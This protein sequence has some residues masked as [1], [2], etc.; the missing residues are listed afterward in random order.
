[1]R[2]AASQCLKLRLHLQ[3]FFVCNLKHNL[4]R[5]L[6]LDKNTNKPI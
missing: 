1:M 2:P 6:L 4:K 5:N 3:Q